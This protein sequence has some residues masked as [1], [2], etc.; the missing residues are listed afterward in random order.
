MGDLGETPEIRD[1]FPHGAPPGEFF[2]GFLGNLEDLE[3]RRIVDGGLDTQHVEMVV[4]FDGVAL[5][6]EFDPAALW[7]L[8]SVDY[9][10]TGEGMVGLAAQKTHDVGGAHAGHGSRDQ[11]AMNALQVFPTGKEDVG[12]VFRLVNPPPVSTEP[13]S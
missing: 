3:L 9:H 6:P 5:E 8:L 12:R 7:P 10:F 11:I 13:F 4:E 1:P 2:A